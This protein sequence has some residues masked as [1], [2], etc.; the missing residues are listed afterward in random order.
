[1]EESFPRGGTQK[2]PEEATVRKRP[3]ENDNLFSTQHEEEPEIK[4]KKEA[5]KKLK[6][7]L[8]EKDNKPTTK[9]PPIDI[10]M[11]KNL[12]VGMLFLGCVK[13]AKDFELVIGLPYGLTGYVHATN[14]CEAYTKLLSEQVKKEDPLEALT[15]LAELYNPGMLIRCYISSLDITT[16]RFNSIKL[17]VDPKHVNKALTS[18]S[19]KAGMLLSGCVSSIEDHG[20]IIDI[21]VSGTKAFLPR[22]KAQLY[23]NQ[24]KGSSLR[25]GQYLN[26]VIEEVKNEGRI[27]RLSI[28]QTDVAGALATVEQNWSLNNLLPGLVL[29]AQIEKVTSHSITLS[30]LQSYTGTVDFLHFEPKKSNTYKKDQEVRA[31]ILWLDPATK[32]IRFT[33][34]HSFLQP[35]VCLQ[36]LTSDMVG[37][38]VDNCTVK[39]MQKHAGAVFDL[40]GEHIGFA[41]K[42][43]LSST[44]MEKF[45]VGSTHKIRI[46]DF[47]PMEEMFLLCLKKKILQDQY[48]RHKDIHAGQMLEGVI[49]SIEPVGMVLKITDHLTGL[50]PKLHFAD[51]VLQHPEKKFTIGNKIKCKVLTVIP[52]AKK[53]ILTRKRTLINSKLPVIASY[54]DAHP[55]LITHGFIVSIQSYGC[56]VKFYNEIQGLAP[57]RE[58][59]S[60]PIPSL[61]DAYYRGQVVK[62]RV[63]EC[64]PETGKILLSFKLQEEGET[65]QEQRY[66]KKI[67]AET[68][69]I[70]KLVD[71]RITTKTDKGLNV[72]ILPEETPAFIPKMHLSDHIT[73]CE[74]LLHT[75]QDGDYLPGGM[76]LSSVKGHTILTMKTAL[77]S[78]FENGLCVKEISEVQIG[79]QLTGFVKN[80][81]PYGVFVEFP[82]GLVGLVPKSEVSDK[83]VTDIR[84]HFVEG[85]TVVAKVTNTDEE[86][87]RFLL[88]LKMSECA[89]DDPSADSFSRLSQCF[90]ELDLLKSFLAKK[91]DS[92]DELNIY[93]L[94]PGKKLTLVVESA[95]D[96]GSVH[97][98]TGIIA[99][100]QSVSAAQH[101]TGEKDLVPGQKAKT[102]VLH[103]DILRSH[104]H[105][106]LYEAIQRKKTQAL[107]KN[108]VYSALVLHVAEE[109]AIISLAD[110]PHLAAVSVSSHFN[111]THRFES[112]KL[113]VGQTISVTLKTT[114]VN[115]YGLLLA[116]QNKTSRKTPV[117]KKKTKLSRELEGGG[118][119][120]MQVGELV[121]GTVKTIKPTQVVVSIN[122][123]LVGFI[124]VSQ[125][126]EDV[127]IGSFPTSKLKPREEVTC[128]VIG[129]R[130]IKSHRF[131]PITHRNFT[132]SVPEL[133]VLPSLVNENTYQ[134]TNVLE[135]YTP[136][137]KVTCYVNKYNAAN[138]YLE[139]EITPELRGRIELLLLSHTPKFLKHPEKHFKAGQALSAT[140]VRKEDSFN[141]LLLSLTDVYSLKNGSVTLAC[142]KKEKQGTGL[143]VSLPF[144][145]IGEASIFHLD[146]CYADISQKKFTCGKF[147]RCA[148]LST[149]KIVQVSLRASRV[150]PETNS[151]V[152]DKEIASIKSLESGQLVKGFVG[153]VTDKGV[154]FRLSSSIVGRIK[155]RNVTRFFVFD[156]SEYAKYIPAGTL[157][158]AK[159]LVVDPEQ[160]HVELSLLPDDT[161]KPDVIP[162]SAGF[163][164]RKNKGERKPGG[165]RKH[166]DSQGGSKA[167]TP[168]R[169]TSQQS[170]E[171]DDSGV[172]VYCR[173]EDEENKGRKCT[174]QSV[175]EPTASRLQVSSGFLWDVNLNNLKTPV[176]AINESN[177]DSEE[178]E[179]DQPKKKKTKKE[180]ATEKKEAEK[181]LS[182]KEASFLDPS[183]LPH[184]ADD[185]DRLVISSP[186]SSILWLQYM[187]FHLHAT[188]IE[189][190]RAVA[191]RALKTISFRE[192]QEKLN[193]WVAFLNLENMYGTEESL[194][195]VFERAVQYNEP[196]KVYHQLA[197]IYIKSEKLKQAEDLYNSMLKRFR[198]E[199]SVWL[200]FATF[201]LKQGQ[202]EATHR[203]LQRALKSLQD[204]DHVDV[205]SKFAQLEFQL[206]DPERAK[207]LFESTLS[208]YTKRTD[209]WSV[210][211]DMMMKYGSQKEVRDIFE[212][213]IHLSLAAKRIKFFFK[214]YLE[215]E[216]KHGTEETIQA[217]KEKALEYVQSK[218]SLT[219][220]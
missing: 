117:K 8:Q 26:C 130:E 25:V 27:V 56:I 52:S 110:T 133:S 144:K 150:N 41:F 147:I 98:S 136:G 83:F 179:D 139:V 76:C 200:K 7:T 77:I 45:T 113:N 92:E 145:K 189:K 90:K 202:A 13:D 53:L 75:L 35:G 111:D 84:D 65:E 155:F 105:V 20:Y 121:T 191:E 50:V 91:G 177:T 146:D 100:A 163:S 14:I 166:D 162:E 34:R 73:N 61:E 112:E 55:G 74:L 24:V 95:G 216:K 102:V 60:I 40:D 97:F 205:I 81:V 80:I 197:D 39:T 183:R 218:S 161:G 3:I 167:V 96:D 93:K 120:K 137:Q 203:L 48:L 164:L 79:M 186:D 88:T 153:A 206:G 131:L 28:T 10:L 138:K 157:L 156:Q 152:E 68:L 17:S 82:Y 70:G 171:D 6:Y 213:V 72:L 181:E 201:V 47:S 199:K 71:T 219:V 16:R 67:K 86:K 4:K 11:Y 175:T 5:P 42:H 51:I 128:R 64:N 178:E 43:N 46:T 125:I 18:G 66:L 188:E 193:V 211:I 149:L 170:K 129:G 21:G 160:E 158:T 192:E 104:V 217:V 214:R 30:F 115:D 154:F 62:V 159:V 196:L 32:R 85:Q 87:K 209:L 143:V 99:G 109:F 127:P 114:S 103:V 151:K 204:K 2:K 176:A 124:H 198:Q 174:T 59:S 184:S 101:Q 15:P 220:T 9:E 69:E 172:E 49:N 194:K 123:K 23:L 185:F 44:N 19:L 1:M 212:R 116:V 165:K 182:K 118:R 180:L 29:K 187:A 58:L 190:A 173:E 33:L 36:Q 22:Q 210:Y 207:A 57:R 119:S 122:E 38:V 108:S 148:V 63:L 140:V 12:N 168:K 107:G 135:K 54:E 195:K 142:V 89:P 126:M 169:K 94:F 31:C 132:Q 208:S 215:Y 141:Q 37:S 78:S 134:R 106:S